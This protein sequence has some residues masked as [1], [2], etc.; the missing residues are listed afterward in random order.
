V[1]RGTVWQQDTNGRYYGVT[2]QGKRSRVLPTLTP[3]SGALTLLTQLITGVNTVITSLTGYDVFG[4]A[5][6]GATVSV[7][8]VARSDVAST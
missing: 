1:L 7:I 8:A 3:L 4:G 6:A 5:A 2:I